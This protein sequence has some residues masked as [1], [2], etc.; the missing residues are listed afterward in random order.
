MWKN[1]NKCGYLCDEDFFY[2]SRDLE[3]HPDG[4]IDTCKDCVNAKVDDNAPITF[5]H[6]LK[7]CDVPYIESVWERAKEKAKNHNC[8]IFGIYMG[9][10][11]LNGYRSFT[12]KDT[13]RLK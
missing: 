4:H 11:K 10:M 8:S 7:E 12:F 6:F 2:Q 5:V 9:I 3:K 13:S 1:C